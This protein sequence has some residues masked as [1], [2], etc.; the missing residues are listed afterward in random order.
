MQHRTA[1]GPGRIFVPTSLAALTLV[2]G[3]VGCS[4]N[5]APQSEDATPANVISA[6]PIVSHVTDEPLSITGEET[7]ADAIDTP[8]VYDLS[9]PTPRRAAAYDLAELP[10]PGISKIL[11]GGLPVAEPDDAV[12]KVA[13]PYELD[14]PGYAAP[15]D[16]VA[17]LLN[18]Q[19]KTDLGNGGE[20]ARWAVVGEQPG[21][22][23]VLIPVGRG[24]LASQDPAQV[25]HH[26][27][28]VRADDVQVSDEPT[29]IVVDVVDHKLSVYRDG[30]ANPDVSFHVGVGLKG[31]TPTPRGLCAVSGHITTQ[32]GQKGL[33]TS[34]QSEVMDGFSG[35]SYAATAIHQGVGFNPKTGAYVSNGCIRVPAQSF[36]EFLADI[37]T[38]T[39]VIF[40]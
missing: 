32:K 33:V 31:K 38:G 12:G 39:V 2:L 40:E 24:A 35:A 29:R 7:D 14:T 27:A 20:G 30:A 21:W 34:C 5:A 13:V 11:P 8:A 1:G 23:E 26:A 6:A 37:P 10:S 25:N 3:A 19:A 4:P 9:T 15:D 36:T 22:V 18:L 17:P 28:W 16:T